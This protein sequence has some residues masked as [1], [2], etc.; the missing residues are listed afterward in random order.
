MKEFC[1]TMPLE[2]ID[3]GAGDDYS[4]RLLEVWRQHEG[5]MCEDLVPLFPRLVMFEGTPKRGDSPDLLLCGNDALSVKILGSGWAECTDEFR[6]FLGKEYCELVGRSYFEAA[7]TAVPV[8]DVVRAEMRDTCGRKVSVF[9]QRLILPVRT[10]GGSRFLFGYSFAPQTVP[11]V[12]GASL[13]GQIRPDHTA[14][15]PDYANLFSAAVSATRRHFGR[16]G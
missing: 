14:K 5:R 8:F 12:R 1:Q 9:Y 10:M 15:K 7:K 16:S 13:V 11:V 4:Q 6:S 2:H 3:Q